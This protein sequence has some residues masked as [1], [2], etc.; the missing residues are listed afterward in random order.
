MAQSS[1]LLGV[2]AQSSAALFALIGGLLASRYVALHAEQEAAE[3]RVADL[4]RRK[5]EAEAEWSEAVSRCDHYWIDSVL[6]DQDVFAAIV[7]ADKWRP[8]VEEVL[9]AAGHDGAGL[10][11][12]LLRERVEELSGS[13][14][15]ARDHLLPLIPDGSHHLE[16][17]VFLQQQNLRPERDKEAVWEWVYDYIVDVKEAAA[18]P[19]PG[20]MHGIDTIALAGLV[21]ARPSTA[22]Q[23]RAQDYENRL[24]DQRDNTKAAVTG[25]AAEV[26][27]AREN[28]DAARQPAGF[29]LALRALTF[30]A[31]TGICLPLTLMTFLP[32]KTH[33]LVHVAVLGIFLTGVFV[34]LRYLFVYAHFLDD[35][36][37]RKTLPKGLFGL[38]RRGA[39]TSS[40]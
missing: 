2:V 8:T 10:N 25:L 3:R 26:R 32:E 14:R 39:R 17:S 15:R 22:A 18:R 21:A 24:I 28:L 37:S 35:R 36:H 19:R 27:L 5:V 23:M 13:F 1:D 38:L 6:E 33:W 16:W 9:Q 4:S 29:G 11:G 20:Y 31:V 12:D 34:L 7:A 30:L 40:G